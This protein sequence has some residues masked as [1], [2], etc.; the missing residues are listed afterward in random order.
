MNVAFVGVGTMGAPMA[1]RVLAA[2]HEIVVVDPVAAAVASLVGDGAVAGSDVATAARDVDA[3]LLS[4]PGP[5]EVEAVVDE[6]LRADSPP[7]Y[8][9]DL[10]TNSPVVVRALAERC[11]AAGST[12]VDAPVS[13]GVAKAV[14]GELSVMVGATPEVFADV[15]PLLSA[16]GTSV[17]SVGPVGAGTV[18][19]LVNNQLFLAGAVLVQEAY[20]LA[21][22]HGLEP[23]DLHPILKASSAGAY[24]GLAPLL[25]GRRFDDVIFR[26]DIAAKDLALAVAAAEE[27]GVDVAA[28]RAASEI[29]AAA[30]EHGD[31]Q[32]VF[33]ATLRELERRAGTELPPLRRRDP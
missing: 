22:A 23:V 3:V 21:A 30:V 17:F 27:A 9:I 19:K 33:H 6:V 1:R 26:L 10:S 18:A 2:G 15:E 16:I 14:T 31:G 28:S 7:A 11:A 20:L 12:F 13:G 8:V 24:V 29:Y 25:L 5:H 32:Q 4:L